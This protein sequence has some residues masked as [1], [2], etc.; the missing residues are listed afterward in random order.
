M[1]TA[2][3]RKSMSQDLLPWPT[4]VTTHLLEVTCPNGNPKPTYLSPRANTAVEPECWGFSLEKLTRCSAAG[5]VCRFA[6]TGLQSTETAKGFL[7][8]L[9]ST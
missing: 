9:Q 4:A 5:R 6:T 7:T 1:V 3:Q 2:T 8:I